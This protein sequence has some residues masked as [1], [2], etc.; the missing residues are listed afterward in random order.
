MSWE[1]NGSCLDIDEFNLDQAWVKQPRLYFTW[2]KKAADARRDMDQLK[3]DLEVTR[4]EIDSDVRRDPNSFGIETKITEKVVEAVVAQDVRC[5]GVLKRMRE[6]KHRFDV[7]SAVVASLDQRKSALEQLV[8]LR[9][10]DYYSE[11]RAPKDKREEMEEVVKRETRRRGRIGRDE[12][13]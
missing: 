5:V 11:P 12:D 6:A 4:A 1:E 10:A 2:A 9:L 7:V 8:R 13:G 3:A